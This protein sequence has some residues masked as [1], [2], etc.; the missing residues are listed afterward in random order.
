M[1]QSPKPTTASPDTRKP[2]AKPS[3]L[4]YGSVAELTALTGAANKS[5]NPL[6]P[7]DMGSI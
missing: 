7:S 4:E 6:N 5:D 3:L 1:A 2:Y